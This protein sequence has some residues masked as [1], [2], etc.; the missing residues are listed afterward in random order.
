MH[1]ALFYRPG[2]RLSAVELRA[3]RLDG[4]VIE[5]G[6]GY[7][8]MDTVEG[9]DA[10]ATGIAGLVP[11]HTAA[12]GPSAAWIHGAGDT[13][14]E[15]HHVRRTSSTRL[16]PVTAGCV[17]YHE[18]RA[19]PEDVLVIG[20]V[21]VTGALPTAMEL[22]FDAA[23]AHADVP[24]LRALLLVHPGLLHAMREQLDATPRRPGRR[25]AVRL[26]EELEAAERVRTS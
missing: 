5:L 25:G 11:A 17:R 7:M 18:G 14:P 12:C 26:M 4:H 23:L 16:R 10:R 1:P 9:A 13:P 6:E 19:N 21:H 22:L 3:A 15:L 20:G 2:S 24:W 8:P